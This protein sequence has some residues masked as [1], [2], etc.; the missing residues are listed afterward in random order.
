MKEYCS[1]TFCMV[2]WVIFRVKLS[3]GR[4]CL[5]ETNENIFRIYKYERQNEISFLE[6]R[7]G[8]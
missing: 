2:A 7:L 5:S 3:F 4:K 6:Y 8:E 1:A